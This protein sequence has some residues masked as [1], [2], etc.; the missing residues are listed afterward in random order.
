MMDPK[1]SLWL[2]KPITLPTARKYEITTW[3]TAVAAFDTA[4]APLVNYPLVLRADSA[5]DLLVNADYHV[6]TSTTAAEVSTNALGKLSLSSLATS[7]TP[8]AF[9]LSGT[10]VPPQASC[11][12]GAAVNDY[13]ART[14]SLSGKPRFSPQVV[15]QIGQRTPCHLRMRTR[16]TRPSSNA[17]AWARPRPRP[18]C[19]RR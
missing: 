7:L 15:Q 14:G 10:A 6:V 11:S 18:A 1:T 12:P 19:C 2:A 5:I 9:V 3:Q 17:R 4:G 8:P 13:F 16:R